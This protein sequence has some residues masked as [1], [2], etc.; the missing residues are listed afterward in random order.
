VHNKGQP[1]YD[2]GLNIIPGRVH[3][4]ALQMLPACQLLGKPTCNVAPLRKTCIPTFACHEPGCLK[5]APLLIRWIQ[6]R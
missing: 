6:R 5:L 2:Y 4:Q 1:G 3:L